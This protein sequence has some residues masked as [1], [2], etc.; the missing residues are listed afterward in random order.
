MTKSWDSFTDEM[1]LTYMVDSIKEFIAS[2]ND[3]ESINPFTIQESNA[4]LKSIYIK[5]EYAGPDA[6]WNGG[7]CR[8]ITKELKNFVQ[9]ALAPT[10][11]NK[12]I[13]ELSEK[14]VAYGFLP[15][16]K[17]VTFDKKRKRDEDEEDIL[18]YWM[19]RAKLAEN[20]LLM[21]EPVIQSYCNAYNTVRYAFNVLNDTHNYMHT[22][23]DKMTSCWV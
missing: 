20:K 21:L 9:V 4:I 13:K 14:M 16:V 3:G 5:E 23:I 7:I 19:K 22:E 10:F 18:D 2:R 17:I 11:E 1:K 8:M 15:D 6:F 12:T